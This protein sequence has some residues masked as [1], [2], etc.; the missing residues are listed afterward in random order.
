LSLKGEGGF[1]R[2]LERKRRTK[3][4]VTSISNPLDCNLIF[5]KECYSEEKK[6]TLRK[7]C[8]GEGPEL[9]KRGSLPG[10]GEKPLVGSRP[11]EEE[12]PESFSG[13]GEKQHGKGKKGDGFLNIA[14]KSGDTGSK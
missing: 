9:K 8:D 7:Y 2:C 11:W 6:G 14:Q 10:E 5:R 3:K 13:K 1:S 12:F 4:T